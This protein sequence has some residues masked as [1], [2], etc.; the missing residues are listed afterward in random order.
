MAEVLE[1]AVDV[2]ARRPEQGNEPAIGLREEVER[3]RSVAGEHRLSQAGL[4]RR[5]RVQ[6]VQA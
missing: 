2:G 4:V 6:D 3:G 5:A 1:G